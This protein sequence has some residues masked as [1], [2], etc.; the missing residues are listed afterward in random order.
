MKTAIAVV[1]SGCAIFAAAPAFADGISFAKGVKA[2][3][4]ALAEYR[5]ALK[6]YTVDPEESRASDKQL[7]IAFNALDDDGRMAKFTCTVDRVTRAAAVER[8][9]PKLSD[10]MLAA[11]AKPA[12]KLAEADRSSRAR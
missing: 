4:A 11:P 3:K 9:K 6:R 7:W 10:H 12:V 1:L 8:K 5:P 2:C